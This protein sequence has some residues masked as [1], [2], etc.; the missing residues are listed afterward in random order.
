MYENSTDSKNYLSRK[1]YFPST[2]KC[3]FFPQL[4]TPCISRKY[5][6]TNS[7]SPKWATDFYLKYHRETRDIDTFDTVDIFI[8]L[9]RVVVQWIWPF[10]C[11]FENVESV[12][13]PRGSNPDVGAS[14]FVI[15]AQ[16]GTTEGGPRN[17]YLRKKV[18]R[19]DITFSDRVI[20]I[21]LYNPIS[22]SLSLSLSLALDLFYSS[23]AVSQCAFKRIVCICNYYIH[24]WICCCCCYYY[25]YY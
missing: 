3:I 24:K 25:Y 6:S 16:R 13:R 18:H 9:H 1:F 23:H 10:S 12:P 8:Q 22:L 4:S 7:R 21:F 17:C 14:Q 19:T 15:C 20:T 2:R 5:L 11:R